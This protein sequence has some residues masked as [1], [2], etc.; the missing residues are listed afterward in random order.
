MY[1][2]RMNCFLVFTLICRQRCLLLF[3]SLLWS[4]VSCSGPSGG[5]VSI[6][7][8]AVMPGPPSLLHLRPGQHSPR[9]SGW[10]QKQVGRRTEKGEFFV[11]LFAFFEILMPCQFLTHPYMLMLKQ[12]MCN[13]SAEEVSVPILTHPRIPDVLLLPVD[14]PRYV[15][16]AYPA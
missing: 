5:R 12:Q 10:D 11:L 7:E 8:A 13:L 15:R 6:P 2:T 9:S 4:G 3:A 14:G 16:N 1:I